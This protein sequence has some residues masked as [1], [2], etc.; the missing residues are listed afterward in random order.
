M[1]KRDGMVNVRLM[2]SPEEHRKLKKKKEDSGARSWEEW[3]LRIAG[4]E[5]E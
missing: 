4:I 2:F 1:A 3:I 5:D